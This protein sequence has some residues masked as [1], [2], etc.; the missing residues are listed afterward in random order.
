LF[1]GAA[2]LGLIAVPFTS[3]SAEEKPGS[4]YVQCDGQPDNVTDGETAA[5][6]LGAVTLL[7]LFAPPHEAADSS[8]RKFGAAGVN[9][10][11][12][13]LSGERQESNPRRRLGL[14]FGRAIHEIEAKNYAAAIS[15]VE[16]GR[17]E[18]QAAGFTNDAYFVRSR[19]RAFD[20]IEGAALFR[21]GRIEDARTASLKDTGNDQF[22]MIQLLSA[23][24]YGDFLEKISPEEEQVSVWT[25]RLMPPMAGVRAARLDLGGRFAESA[26]LWDALSEM[27]AEHT[28][29]VN[30]SMTIARAAIA[31]A[32]AGNFAVAAQRAKAARDN[33]EKR[34][35]EGKPESDAAE[36]VEL[37]DFYGIIEQ[38]HSGDVKTA[39]RLFAARSQWLSASLGSVME[40]SRRL[41]EG[42]APDELIGGLA[43]SPQE[44]WKDHAET[45]RAEMLAQDSD[46]KSLFA[47]IPAE[48]SGKLYLAVAKNVWRADNSKIVLKNPKAD[49]SKSRLEIMYLPLTDPIVALDAYVLH[50]ALIARSR[51]QQGFVFVP[52]LTSRT[53]VGLFRTG[54]QGDRGFPPELFINANDVIQKLSPLIPMPTN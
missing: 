9:A 34:R 30:S 45:K 21:M 44:L 17:R 20:A 13:L 50:A 31:H 1:L 37:L 39:R 33:S 41:R 6:L 25:A 3:A 51:G 19:G 53:L 18:A 27:D 24:T 5:R 49:P 10:C 28:P 47:L 48:R 14:I 42:A 2:A 11:T 35:L 54:N 32:L 23:A 43:K 29:E 40:M 52:T 46:N 16:M 8:K 7:G 36:L 15:D 22:S 26:R 4:A 12:S 38:V